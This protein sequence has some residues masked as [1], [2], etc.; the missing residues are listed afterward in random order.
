MAS[1]SIEALRREFDG[2]FAL[3]AREVASDSLDLLAIRI[4]NE[5][6]ALRVSEIAG[7]VTG[8]R[9]TPVPSP[10]PSLM[11]LLGVRGAL[12]AVFDLGALLGEAPMTA[13]PRWVA[14]CPGEHGL[15]VAFPELEGH[16]KLPSTAVRVAEGQRRELV[17]HSIQTE[18][19]LYPI[20][21]IP[22]ILKRLLVSAGV[23]QPGKETR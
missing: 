19:E 18:A 6:F 9:L 15:A 1:L 23:Q 7:L 12:V 16:L 10:L 8:H 17:E 5:P 21:S 20:A 14:L 13:A 4:D 22:R 3:P 11:G 2:S